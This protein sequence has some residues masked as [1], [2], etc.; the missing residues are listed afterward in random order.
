MSVSSCEKSFSKLNLIKSYLQSTISQDRVSNLGILSIE[1]DIPLSLDYS[2][3]IT[4]YEA[5][6]TKK[7][8]F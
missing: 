2:D 6:K 1:N 3:L 5:I 4:N 8:T 7:V